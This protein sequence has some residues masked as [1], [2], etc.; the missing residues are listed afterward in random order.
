MKP[1][2]AET[3]HELEI[4]NVNKRYG[5]T[6]AVDDISLA[7][8]RGE[9]LTILGPSGSGK[10]TLL[11][12]IAG[13]VFPTAG[14]IIYR[15]TDITYMPAHLRSMG[16]VFQNYALFPHMTVAQNL[17][18]PLR[19]RRVPR[20][21]ADRRVRETLELVGLG[22][23]AG[24]LPAQL[25]GGQ[26]QR[27]AVARALV[28]RPSLLLMDEPLGALDKYLRER[29]QR[30][31]KLIQR[32]TGVTI[33]YVTHDQQEALAMSDRIAVM[34]D[35]RVRALGTAQEIYER[36]ATRFIA[37]FIGDCNFLQGSVV[38]TAG[39]T[40]DVRIAGDAA[41]TVLTGGRRPA[42]GSTVTVC[43]RPESV[44]CYPQG[45]R[46][47]ANDSETRVSLPGCISDVMYLGD[48]VKYEV[49]IPDLDSIVRVQAK[50]LKVARMPVFSRGD[51]VVVGWSLDDAWA[52]DDTAH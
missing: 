38:R 7:V 26:Q 6:V 10:T 25:S 9:F 48:V 42:A 37:E 27:V 33:V 18:F 47:H 29:L 11:H 40:C 36:P 43:V 49:A 34:S 3:E 28:Y 2:A 1:L 24:R 44:S 21:E 35:G 52:I 41:V 30:E 19:M 16:M 4:R 5:H 32:A 8:R 12:M 31:I 22:S 46:P 50:S 23:Q 13:F 15:G 51:R 20:A 39:R 17:A 45:T 14:T